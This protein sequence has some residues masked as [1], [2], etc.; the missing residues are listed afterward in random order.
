MMPR[1]RYAQVR[2]SYEMLHS[3][4]GLDED[5]HIDFIRSEDA[6]HVLSVHVSSDLD[7]LPTQIRTFD[8]GE[9]QEV[10]QHSMTIEEMVE[11]MRRRIQ[12]WDEQQAA[13]IAERE[14]RQAM[15]TLYQQLRGDNDGDDTARREDSSS[16]EGN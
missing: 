7:V 4:L 16:Q 15:N 11:N 5:V 9:G 8:R 6:R 12:A 1:R 2:F 14:S 10:I 3:L 13:N